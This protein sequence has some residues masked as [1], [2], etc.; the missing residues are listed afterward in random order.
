MVVYPKLEKKTVDTAHTPVMTACKRVKSI[1]GTSIGCA[2]TDGITEGS[3]C[4]TVSTG[5]E[6]AE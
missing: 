6:R 2:V 3:M 1:L 4:K 5:T